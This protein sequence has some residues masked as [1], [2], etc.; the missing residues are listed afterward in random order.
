MAQSGLDENGNVTIGLHYTYW[1]TYKL[2]AAGDLV[3]LYTKAGTDSE[4]ALTTGKKAHFFYWGHSSAI[5]DQ[6]DRAA[7]LLNAPTW[8]HKSVKALLTRD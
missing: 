2:V 3:V 4:K 6:P 7:V 1:F 5:W 8:E